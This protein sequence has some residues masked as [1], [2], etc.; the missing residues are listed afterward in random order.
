MNEVKET[1]ANQTKKAAKK[2]PAKGA[3]TTAPA[4]K[5]YQVPAWRKG[6]NIHQRV[7]GAIEALVAVGPIERES[8][9]QQQSYRFASHNAIKEALTPILVRFG[10]LHLMELATYESGIRI[11]PASTYQGNNQSD[12]EVYWV[13]AQWKMQLVNI[14]APNDCIV[15]AKWPSYAEFHDDY[16]QALAQAAAAVGGAGGG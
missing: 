5:G 12:K 16:T 9:N 10:I 15:F 11:Q 2:G 7:Q 3:K 4:E 1:A 6:M 8:T 14:D 13:R